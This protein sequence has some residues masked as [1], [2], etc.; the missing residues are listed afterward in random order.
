MRKKKNIA[1]SRFTYWALE[2]LENHIAKKEITETATGIVLMFCYNF[3]NTDSGVV[4][5]NGKEKHYA[6]LKETQNIAQAIQ[7][8]T[9]LQSSAVYAGL[10]SLVNFGFLAKKYSDMTNTYKYTLLDPEFTPSEAGHTTQGYF[11]VP[12]EIFE[13]NV[14]KTLAKSREI[15]Y[16]IA[17]LTMYKEVSQHLG[18]VGSREG[19]A[20]PTTLSYTMEKMKLLLT[21]PTAKRKVPASTVRK[22]FGGYFAPLFSYTWSSKNINDKEELKVCLAKNN[23]AD[24]YIE[25]ITFEV[26]D[27]CLTEKDYASK[28][29]EL[30]KMELHLQRSFADYK[31]K[32][33]PFDVQRVGKIFVREFSDFFDSFK[34]SKMAFVLKAKMKKTSTKKIREHIF[35]KAALSFSTSLTKIDKKNSFDFDLGAWAI[36]KTME[37]LDKEIHAIVDDTTSDIHKKAHAA[38]IRNTKDKKDFNGVD[39]NTVSLSFIKAFVLKNK[40]LSISNLIF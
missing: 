4:S 24:S 26:K 8:C 31:G 22:V 13:T 19:I 34:K 10:K 21:S 9:G 6:D 11:R 14:L 15:Q 12:F 1:G 29:D 32:L 40:R 38:Y 5:W 33:S 27:A 18:G 7:D 37:I 23:Y 35:I 2:K 30:K 20:H 3:A 39:S 17:L 25:K 36:K 16:I 28:K